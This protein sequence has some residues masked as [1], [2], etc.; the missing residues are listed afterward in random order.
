MD[1]IIDLHTST[2]NTGNMAMI[3]GGKEDIVALRVAHHLQ[4]HGFPEL[5][6]TVSNGTKAA[7]Y[8]LDSLAPSG[9]AFE[10]GPLVHGTITSAALETTR[11]LVLATLDY[12]DQRNQLLLSGSVP[13]E[14]GKQ[15]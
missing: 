6:I 1:F 4:S 7:A 14:A 13:S 11:S 8:S 2:S 12:I 15:G 5:R 3:A 9:L 10:V